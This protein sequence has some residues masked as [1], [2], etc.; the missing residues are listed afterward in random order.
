MLILKLLT[1]FMNYHLWQNCLDWD[2]FIYSGFALQ[3]SGFLINLA[4]QSS[5]V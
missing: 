1:S 3:A 4:D 5:T 2:I